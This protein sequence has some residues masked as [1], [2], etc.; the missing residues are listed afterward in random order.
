M[1]VILREEQ[2]RCDRNTHRNRRNKNGR[3]RTEMPS[4]NS[5]PVNFFVIGLAATGASILI[6]V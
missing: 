5:K 3:R 2:N 1:I 6:L 4:K